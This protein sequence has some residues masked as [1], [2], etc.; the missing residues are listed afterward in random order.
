MPA[1]HTLFEDSRLR[2]PLRRGKRLQRCKKTLRR[3]HSLR[4]AFSLTELLVVIAIII[5]LVGLLLVALKQVQVKVKRTRTERVM[6]QFANA[7][8]AFQAETGRYPGVIPDDVLAAAANPPISC[9]E[10]ALLDLAG[11][12]RLVSPFDPPGGVVD[13]DYMSYLSSAPPAPQPPPVQ[14]VFV[15]PAGQW[16]LVIAK[17]RLGEGPVINGK[18]HAPFFTPGRDDFQPVE[19]QV[20]EPSANFLP[21]LVDAWDHPILYIKRVRDRGPLLQDNPG[22]PQTPAPQFLMAGMN[23]Y[24]SMQAESNSVF[25]TAAGLTDTQKRN[26]WA[27]ILGHP[28]FY[29]S[30]SP[31]YGQTRGEFMLL[32]AGPDGVFFATTDGPGS[33]AVPISNMNVDNL[34]INAGPKVIDEFDDVR[35]YGGG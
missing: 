7:C 30:A 31:L 24:L 22:P 35:W 21:D 5:L 27:A 19:G 25:S 6:Q 14:L 13:Q 1:M 18:P 32:S 23:A 28:A 11:G 8:I 15:S 12:F 16:K 2:W 4:A 29:K 20:G 9:T 10:N 3:R 33:H 17:H 34:I 26:V